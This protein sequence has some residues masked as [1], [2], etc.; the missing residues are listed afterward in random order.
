MNMIFDKKQIDQLHEG[1]TLRPAQWSDFE[2]VVDLVR[3]VLTADGD[4]I[5]AVT[6]DELE[7]EW[8]TEGFSLETDV[9]IVATADGHVVGYEEFVN[10]HAHA[11]LQGDG[12]VHPDFR[13]LGIGTT[14][15]CTLEERARQEMRLAEPDLRVAI[16]NGMS[17]TDKVSR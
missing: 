4:A 5:S 14:L 10:R 6:P 1:L 3:V 2:A 12:Y 11:A 8:K 16:M 13:G 17:A 7:R 9:F 15:L